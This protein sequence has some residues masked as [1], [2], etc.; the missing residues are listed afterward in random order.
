[1]L[2]KPAN[3]TIWMILGDSTMVSAIPN[4]T[5]AEPVTQSTETSA[6]KPA[7]AAPRPSGGDSV[8]LSKAAQ[9]VLAV[10][11]EL[12]ET[13]AQ[14]VQEAGHGDLQAQRLLAK[15]ADAKLAD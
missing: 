14:T 15:Q 1:M 5:Q 2:S 8:Q 6:Q 11:Q 10:A 4:A 12:K 3:C 13:N 7:Q 9:A